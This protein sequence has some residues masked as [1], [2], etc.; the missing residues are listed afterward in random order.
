LFAAQTKTQRLK[1]EVP[2]VLYWRILSTKS[3]WTGIGVD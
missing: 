1:N 3:G 2:K